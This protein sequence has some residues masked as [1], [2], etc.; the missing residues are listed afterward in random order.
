MLL[1]AVHGVLFSVIPGLL[2]LAFWQNASAKLPVDLRSA[3]EANAAAV[4]QL[5][6]D[7]TQTRSS[8]LPLQD[9]MKT[10]AESNGALF[11]SRKAT[12][13][14]SGT[15]FYMLDDYKTDVGGIIRPQRQHYAFD[16]IK[17]RIGSDDPGTHNCFSVDTPEHYQKVLPP[18][19]WVFYTEYF[20]AAGIH[21]GN[22]CAEL[23]EPPTSLPLWLLE[24]DKQSVDVL[25]ERFENRECTVLAF[26]TSDRKFRFW[27]RPDM[28][29][30]VVRITE[31]DAQDRLLQE[32][33]NSAFQH[34]TD[35]EVWLPRKC[36]VSHYS[37]HTKPDLVSDTILLTT[38]LEATLLTRNGIEDSRFVIDTTKGG[39]RVADSTIEGPKDK[40]GYVQ[41]N[42]PASEA[43]LSRIAGSR[44]RSILILNILLFSV[45]FSIWLIRR[46]KAGSQQ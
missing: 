32:T 45:L 5:H 46:W 37:W 28:R 30:A 16:G 34:L 6:V 41:F 40:D 31:S 18:D 17:L 3:M 42:V 9:L 23:F 1:R 4:T 11:H 38:L 44:G 25:H 19:A 8:P 10:L 21:I 36:R 13:V 33:V 14:R 15:R 2:T 22:R 29:H 24:S 26:S 27:L 12:Y 7:W 35:P 20:D 39:S 43:D